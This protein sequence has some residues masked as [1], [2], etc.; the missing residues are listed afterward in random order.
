MKK[1][2]Q[3]LSQMKMISRVTSVSL[4]TREV[5][6]KKNRKH[7]SY[8]KNLRF[9]TCNSFIPLHV[10]VGFLQFQVASDQSDVEDHEMEEKPTETD[11]TTDASGKKLVTLNVVKRWEKSCKV[12]GSRIQLLD[13][14]IN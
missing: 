14:H 7:T 10:Y 5:R 13:G 9:V 6:R 8:L 2:P 3:Q 11:S 4:Q 12:G 1:I